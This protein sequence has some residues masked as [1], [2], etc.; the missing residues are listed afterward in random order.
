VDA[1]GVLAQRGI[2]E[3]L[4]RRDGGYVPERGCAGAV[5]NTA[6]REGWI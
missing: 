6:V 3:L 1:A 4:G 2:G 5:V